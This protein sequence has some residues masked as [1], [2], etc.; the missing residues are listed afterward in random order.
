MTALQR[1]IK[2]FVTGGLTNPKTRG[3]LFPGPQANHLLNPGSFHRQ[4]R[5]SANTQDPS[6][7]AS[8]FLSRLNVQ[9]NCLLRMLKLILGKGSKPMR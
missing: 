2:I 9:S 6:R 7:G 3:P 5:E 8:K 4:L 1:E